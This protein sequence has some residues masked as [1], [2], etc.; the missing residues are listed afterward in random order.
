MKTLLPLFLAA[1]IA[2]AAILPDT[3]GD[4]KKG[5]ASPAA[6]P[7]QKVWQEYGLQDSEAAE[8]SAHGAKYS[9]SAYR[10][11][12]ATGAF[13]AFNQARPADAKPLEIGGGL[14]AANAPD[15]VAA[16]GN[17]LFVFRGHK[18]NEE[19]LVHIVSTAPNYSKSRLPTLPRY[20]PEGAEPN[21]ERYIIGPESL[22]K[23]AP[24]IPPSTAAFHF[25]SEGEMAR[26]P[27]KNGKSTTL[28]VFTYPAMEMAR[29]RIKAFRQIPG[30]VAKISGPLVAI[31]T[32]AP[33]PDEAERVLSRVKYQADVSPV[34]H[35]PTLKDNPAN[36]FLNVFIL[37]LILAGIC[38]LGG[39]MV[40]GFRVLVRRAG[41]SGEGDD[42]IS[43]H[44]SGRQ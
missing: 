27:A 11:S 37:C 4:W 26:Y 32:E 41:P 33:T 31:V 13:A 30:A 6:V 44:L 38:I 7:D 17:Y 34:E 21:S 9:I 23:F 1:G 16:L 25:D 35:P 8:Y 40:G 5:A 12:D 22:A 15:E 18:P 10:F 20:V 39:V 19:E 29:D 2:G 42:M 14:G 36:L 3:M 24:S 43:L 28:V